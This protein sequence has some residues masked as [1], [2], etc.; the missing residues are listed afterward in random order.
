MRRNN[1]SPSPRPNP[2]PSR[3]ILALCPHNK[4]TPTHPSTKHDGAVLSSWR[5]DLVQCPVLCCSCL[6]PGGSV[7]RWTSTAQYPPHP[8]PQ[9]ETRDPRPEPRAS[10]GFGSLW[11]SFAVQW[12]PEPRRAVRVWVGYSQRYLSSVQTYTAMGIAGSSKKNPN[13][14]ES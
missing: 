10:F 8:G 3:K 14:F 13:S 12:E 7:G 6:L 11:H 1:P 2:S 9:P 5:K 4:K